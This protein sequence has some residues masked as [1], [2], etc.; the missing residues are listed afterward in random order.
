[1]YRNYNLPKAAFDFGMIFL[2]GGLWVVWMFC[3]RMNRFI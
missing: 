1:M 3:R 2:T